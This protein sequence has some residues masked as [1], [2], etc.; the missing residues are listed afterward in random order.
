MKLKSLA[1][2][3]E[4]YAEFVNNLLLNIH[5][6]HSKDYEIAN[7]LTKYGVGVGVGIITTYLIA[8]YYF[9]V[10]GASA[11][12]KIT[13][14]GTQQT[15]KENF[16]Y[17]K[18]K[19][20]EFFGKQI[21]KQIEN[22][23]GL[24][25]MVNKVVRKVEENQTA[26]HI[27]EIG[28]PE[29]YG[30]LDP[31]KYA[32]YVTDYI[33]NIQTMK[34]I[35]D[36]VY[37]EVKNKYLVGNKFSKVIDEYIKPITTNRDSMKRLLL[38]KVTQSIS[39]R[40]IIEHIESLLDNM[41]RPL[42]NNHKYVKYY[43]YNNIIKQCNLSIT[44]Y[45]ESKH[46]NE[47]LNELIFLVYWVRVLSRPSRIYVYLNFNTLIKNTKNKKFIATLKPFIIKLDYDLML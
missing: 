10:L 20:F 40:T 7:I 30:W 8:N 32:A 34:T 4:H 21:G 23:V 26:K 43:N 16:E 35:Y 15:A 13:P 46:P 31:R 45:F 1:K 5:I 22:N 44:K 29:D 19:L 14:E 39:D 33:K 42:K 17:Y 2:R 9:Y 3:N 37:T 24:Q 36:T 47:Q 25:E 11:I 12:Y 18:N 38:T 28:T 41:G 27:H 6:S